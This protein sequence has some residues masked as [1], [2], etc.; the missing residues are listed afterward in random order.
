VAGLNTASKALALRN[1]GPFSSIGAYVHCQDLM[2]LTVAW[3]A[4]QEKKPS[5]PN[6]QRPAEDDPHDQQEGKGNKAD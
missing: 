3:T 5:V 1:N 4:I 6:P 2:H